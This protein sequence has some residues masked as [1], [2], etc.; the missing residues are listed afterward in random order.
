MFSMDKETKRIIFQVALFIV[1]FVTTTLAGSEW[2]YGRSVFQEDFAWQDFINGLAF[3]IPLLLI[4]TVHEFGHYFMAMYHKVKTSLPY[5]IPIPPIPFLF[6]FG[7]FGAVIRLREK[8]VSTTQ[9]FDIG[10]AGPL[11]GFVVAF[12]LMIYGFATLP[13]AEYVY[14]FHPEYKKYGLNYADHVYNFDSLK[15]DE[16]VIDMRIGKSLMFLI[17]EQFVSDPSRIPNQRELMHY[18]LLF[19]VFF[20]LFVTSINLLPIGQLDGGHVIYGLFGYKKHRIIATIFF[21]ALMFYAGLGNP[22]IQLDLPKDELLLYTPFYVLFLYFAFSTLGLTKRDTFMYA[23][24]VV[25]GQFILMYLIPGIK[26]YTGW[27]ILGFLLA[28][29][30]G[31][32]HPPSEIEQPLDSKRILLGWISLLIFILCFSLTPIDAEVFIGK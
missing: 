19:A 6:S 29:M 12:I 21:V 22:Y 7:T 20:A 10:I 11:A 4:L 31:I 18:P 26:G 5:Y 23:M 2:V 13:P 15:K 16:A 8:P 3:S 9:T 1:T 24:L 28:R 30:V 17:A 25:A 27:L 14:E 32:Q